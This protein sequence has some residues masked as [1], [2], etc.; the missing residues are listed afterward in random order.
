MP[1]SAGAITSRT[2]STALRTPLPRIALRVA[3][4]QLERL[5]LAGRCARRDDRA[6]EGTAV[7]PDLGLDGGV[8]AR[9]QNFARVQPDDL[10]H[11][12][13]DYT[14]HAPPRVISARS[15]RATRPHMIRVMTSIAG[16]HD[17]E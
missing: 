9:I 12:R 17:P 11:A 16:A 4:A 15:A 2:L 7:E 3:V 5:V 8:A 1:M 13:D 14:G 6:A 10:G